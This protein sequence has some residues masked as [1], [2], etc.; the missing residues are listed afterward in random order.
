MMMTKASGAIKF[1]RKILQTLDTKNVFFAKGMLWYAS[2][3]HYE[4]NDEN[5]VFNKS[6]QTLDSA[7]DWTLLE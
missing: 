5:T 4:I 2:I 7:D 3:S 1:A 6:T